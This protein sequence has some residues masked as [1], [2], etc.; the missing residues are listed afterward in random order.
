MSAKPDLLIRG[1]QATVNTSWLK[2]QLTAGRVALLALLSL[3]AACGGTLAAVYKGGI[4]LPAAAA[5]STEQSPAAEGR[6]VRIET[7]LETQGTAVSE[8]QAE[9][10]R[11]TEILH[12]LK[13]GIDVLIRKEAG[14]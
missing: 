3:L 8:M 13:G 12:E 6:L 11:Q 14:P 9:Q 7:T 1:D 5:S 4:E 2:R 10:K